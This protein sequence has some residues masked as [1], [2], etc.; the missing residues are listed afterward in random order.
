MSVVTIV[1]GMD[2]SDANANPLFYNSAL[3]FLMSKGVFGMSSMINKT[4]SY[5]KEIFA[6][7][8]GGAVGE[9]SNVYYEVD[10]NKP[11]NSNLSGILG[12]VSLGYVA[13][14]KAGSNEITITWYCWDEIDA[15]SFSSFDPVKMHTM[16]A[17]EGS[18]DVVWDK[19][20]QS[21][22]NFRVTKTETIFMPE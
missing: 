7:Y 6:H 8:Q 22:F 19:L 5:K 21:W 12:T 9:F 10:I 17:L 11:K 20:L 14:R 13:N 3:H 1:S 15:R 4:E 2:Y 16:H 18:F